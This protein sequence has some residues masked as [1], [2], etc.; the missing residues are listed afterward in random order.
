MIAMVGVSLGVTAG[1]SAT[2]FTSEMINISQIR[3]QYR[4]AQLL[5]SE[6]LGLYSVFILYIHSLGRWWR[7]NSAP[8]TVSW[9]MLYFRL[10][11]MLYNIMHNLILIIKIW[12]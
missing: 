3:Q 5:K 2:S 8:K 10:F 12:T 7:G 6:F 4:A 9:Q 1:K 11:Y